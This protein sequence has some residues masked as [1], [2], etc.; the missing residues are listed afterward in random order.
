ML[1]YRQ[2]KEKGVNEMRTGYDFDY[3]RKLI[4]ELEHSKFSWSTVL[5]AIQLYALTTSTVA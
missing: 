3:E 2:S 4:D 1:Q 5:K